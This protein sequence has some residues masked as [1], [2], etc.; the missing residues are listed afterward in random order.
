[1]IENGLNGFLVDREVNAIA[2]KLQYLH[3]NRDKLTD[4]GNASRAR[5]EENWSW[6]IRVGAWLNFIEENI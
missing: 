6:E 1:M 5:I 4:L 2:E 3:E